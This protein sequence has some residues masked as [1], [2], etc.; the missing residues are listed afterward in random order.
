[1]SSKALAAVSWLLTAANAT[2]FYCTGHWESAATAG[3]AALV[4]IEWTVCAVKDR[5][6]AT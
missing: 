2:S 5:D 3:L 1:M 6:D 4:A